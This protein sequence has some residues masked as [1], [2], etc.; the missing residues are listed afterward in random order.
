MRRQ[1]LR[2]IVM[3]SALAALGH[4]ATAHADW[5]VRRTGARELVEQAARALAA[6]PEDA[7]LAARLVRLAGKS[8][9]PALRVRFEAPAREPGARYAEVAAYATLLLALGA[10]EDAAVAFARAAALRPELAMLTGRARALERAGRPADA[11]A[12]YDDAVARARA[13]AERRRLLEAQVALV[14]PGDAERELA[15]RRALAALEPRSED[16]AARVVDVLER[17][18]RPAEA[19]ELLEARDAADGGRWFERA[20]RLAELRD[21][22]GDAARAADV[23]AALLARLPRGQVERRRLAWTRAL[24]IAR[25]RDALPALAEA[26]GRAPGPVEWD[27]LA[28]V[29]DELGDLEGALEAAR[30]AAGVRPGPELGRRIV[31][32]LDRLGRD[33]EAVAVYEDLVRRAPDDPS[34]AL[35]LVERELRRGRRKPAE[36]HFDR[37]AA[38]F[39]GSP[40]AMVRLAELASRWGEDERAR[41]AWERVRRLAPRDEQGILGLGETQ[42]A[43][44]KR[45]LALKTW[46]SLREREPGIAGRLRL[47]EVLLDHDLL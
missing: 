10:N 44:G 7:A 18:G 43:S 40:S 4:G 29:R 23:L 28:Q 39:G 45:E 26:L 27:V 16:A 41:A 24:G 46:R 13:P 9:A 2:A 3:A 1:L 15:L 37:A 32:L 6:R 12:A 19:A 31:A 22:A 20:L 35:E 34:W 38:R 17:L 5:D 11:L 47:A 30:R 14:P 21:A 42:F 8:G 33:D 25:H 36:A